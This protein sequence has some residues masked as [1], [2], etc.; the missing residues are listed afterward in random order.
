MEYAARVFQN[1][2][3]P[4]GGTEVHAVVEVAVTGESTVPSNLRAAE[5]I[6]VDAS[7]S[8][9]YKGKMPAAKKATA[10]A[11]DCIRDGVAFG[12]IAG[13]DS[14]VMLYPR[15]DRLAIASDRARREAKAEVKRLRAGGGTAMG[16][17]L[18][19]A[20]RWFAHEDDAICHALLLTDGMNEGESA[21]ELLDALDRV[22]GLFQCDCRGVGSDWQVTELRTIASTLLGTVEMIREPSQMAA[23]FAAITQRSMAKRMSEVI[24]RISTPPGATLAFVKQIADTVEDLTTRGTQVDERSVDFPTGAWGA[25]SRDFHVAVRVPSRSVGDEMLAARVSLVVNGDVVSQSLVR[26]Q[27]TDDEA[28]STRIEGR[29]AFHTGQSELASAIADG[30][31]ARRRGDESEA[32]FRLGEAV[33]LAAAVGDEQKLQCLAAV[34]EIED[35]STG[36]VRLKQ[37]VDKADEMELDLASSK[38]M[39]VGRT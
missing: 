2:F 39:R 27:W 1:E 36:T 35:A 11:V 19:A 7:G 20:S 8:M 10:T 3:L 37:R 21:A 30:L 38:T 15:G 16:R 25:E 29:V 22:Q 34:V 26:A 31:E 5:V 9:D 18:T 32:T 23:D 14:G 6:I 33:R 28:L 17:W 13:T 24:L 4:V 12:V